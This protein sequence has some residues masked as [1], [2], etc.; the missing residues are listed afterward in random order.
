[1]NDNT[2]QRNI[3]TAR[4]LLEDAMPH[5]DW[6]LIRSLVTADAL[7]T[8]AGFADLYAAT[9]A[10]I[11]QSGTFVEWLETGWKKLSEGLS[12]K[13]SEATDVVADG[14]TVLMKFHMTALHS[15]TFAGAPATGR[16]VAWDEIAVLHFNDD[17]KITDMWYMCQE[18]GLA[19]QI[20]Y[21]LQR[22]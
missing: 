11:P 9:D 21:R 5:L 20:G 18:L 1:M 8:R 19:A 13:T 17:G 4:T 2:A 22:A 16:R 15:G 10:D 12:D 7:I 14:N 6:D 3:A